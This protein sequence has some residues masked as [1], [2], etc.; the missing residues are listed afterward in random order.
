MPK[1]E[2]R[3][4][5]VPTVA[6]AVLRVLFASPRS[7]AFCASA[8]LI[9]PGNETEARYFFESRFTPYLAKNN[10]KSRCLFTG[11]YEPELHGA[12]KPDTT[13]RYPIYARP[14]DLVSFDLGD[15]RDEFKGWQLAG[16]LKGN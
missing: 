7:L 6:F 5:V 3:L 8:A 13:Y 1:S 15:F 11:Y 14:K 16:Q 10:I 4:R 12:W 9:H 2:R